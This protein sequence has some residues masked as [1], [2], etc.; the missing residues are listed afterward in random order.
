MT[1]IKNYVK[2]INPFN[3]MEEMPAALYIIKKVLAFLIIYYAVG[4]IVGEG[5]IIGGL[6][7]M[8]YDPLHGVMPGEEI[9]TLIKYYGFIS[10]LLL[11]VLYCR[12]IE[13]RSIQSMGFNKHICDYILGVILAV[14]LLSI[15]MGICCLM[16][17]ISYVGVGK[18]INYKYMI[19][20]LGGLIIQGA[21][22][23]ALC[24]GFLMSSLLK[25]VSVPVAIIVNATVFAFPHFSS[26]FEAEFKFAVLG[27]INLYLI[28]VI[29]SMLILCRSNIWVS[30]GLHSIW[31]FLLYG[32]FGLTLSGSKTDTTG[33]ICFEVNSSNVINGGVYGVEASIITTVILS[34]VVIVLC[35]YWNTHRSEKKK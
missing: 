31:N 22:E 16:G 23:E 15:I 29:F 21:T 1:Q 11:T 3:N 28:S 25:R 2:M 19:A 12:F 27:V 32:V 7:I 8:G 20:L 18:D 35:R 9:L 30:C 10:F 13:K 17:G 14:I 4:L 24:R 6:S 33:L 5:I 34:I 26:L